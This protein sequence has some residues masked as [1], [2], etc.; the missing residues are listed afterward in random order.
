M[1]KQCFTKLRYVAFALFCALAVQSYN[2]P[3]LHAEVN[4]PL[5]I[6]L[7]EK[8]YWVFVDIQNVVLEIARFYF[9]DIYFGKE[10]KIPMFSAFDKVYREYLDGAVKIK[11]K[12]LGSMPNKDILEELYPKFGLGSL[13]MNVVVLGLIPILEADNY[14]AY[15][16]ITPI[17]RE[18]FNALIEI[19]LKDEAA[20]SYY[21]EQKD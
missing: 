8:G 20:M 2:A 3:A 21:L 5:G 4:I 16:K 19:A 11:G 9:Y 17:K 7:N 18:L 13:H 1:K 10:A 14:R 6:P 15:A 12:T